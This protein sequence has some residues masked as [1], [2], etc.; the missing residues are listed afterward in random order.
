[1]CVCVCVIFEN[2]LRGEICGRIESLYSG[3]DQMPV[4]MTETTRLHSLT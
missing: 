2:K 1:M 3:Q 4:I